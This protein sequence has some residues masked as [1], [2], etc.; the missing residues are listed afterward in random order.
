MG[1]PA[2]QKDVDERPMRR[3]LPLQGFGSQQRSERQAPDDRT[4]DR[5]E[6]TS[7]RAIAEP[8]SAV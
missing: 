7:R 4:A 8:L 1:R 5:E 3:A 2:W 6:V